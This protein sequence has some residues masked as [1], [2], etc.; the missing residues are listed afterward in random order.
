M[1]V[2]IEGLSATALLAMPDEELDVLVL[3]DEPIAFRAGTAEVLGRFARRDAR[4]VM[5]TWKARPDR[6]DY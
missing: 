4:L 5:E 6:V 2:D 3:S 1:P